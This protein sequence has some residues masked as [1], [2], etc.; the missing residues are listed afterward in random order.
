MATREQTIGGNIKRFRE[1]RGI[2]Q[3]VLAQF[4][5]LDQTTIS[6]IEA[7][8]RSIKVSLLERL[9]NLFACSLADFLNESPDTSSMAQVAFRA[10]ESSVG[11]LEVLAVIG[12]IARNLDEMTRLEASIHE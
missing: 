9:S 2:T 6:K 1:Q 5:G 7:G 12:R 4:L 10:Q 8:Q 11:D 3:A